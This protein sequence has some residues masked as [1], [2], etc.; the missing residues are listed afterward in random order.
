MAGEDGDAM[1]MSVTKPGDEE[2]VVIT[3]GMTRMEKFV[4]FFGP[5]LLIATVY[6]DPGQIVV[7]MESG[8][9]FQYRLLWVLFAANGMGLLFQHLCSRLSVVTGRNMAVE[10]RL[11]Y[12]KNLRVFLWFTV[13]LASIAADLGYVMGTATALSILFGLQLHWGV[14]LTGLDTFL[15][16]GLQ[17]FGIRKVEALVGSLFGMVVVAYILEMFFIQP[18][19]LGIV[20]GCLPR[21]WHKNALFGYDEWLRL[22]CANLG[23]A[24]CPPN[25]FL[26]S[27]LVRTRKTDR[28]APAVLE[29]FEY[30]LYE[31]TIC[32]V[33][34]TVIN[35]VMLILAAAHFY[36][37]K[38]VS[39]E[40]GADLLADILGSFARYAFAIAMLCAGQSSSLTGVLSTQYIMEGFFELSIPGWI[41]RVATRILA[42]VPAF[43]VVY[44]YGANSA[45]ELIE[46]AQV[47]VNF[48]VP[49]TVI[50]LTKFL[51]SE[52]KMG[53]FRLSNQLQVICWACSGIAI[54]LNVLALYDFFSG[55]EAIPKWMSFVIGSGTVGVYFAMSY[56][57]I[58]RP[59]KVGTA[60]LWADDKEAKEG[61]G[62][63]F[64][65]GDLAPTPNVVRGLFTGGACFVVIIAVLAFRE[66]GS[67]GCLMDHVGVYIGDGC[68]IVA[69]RGRVLNSP[70]P[71]ATGVPPEAS[72]LD[73]SPVAALDVGGAMAMAPAPI[74][75]MVAAEPLLTA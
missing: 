44:T 52:L 37:V 3:M 49:F 29:A 70:P 8:S 1:S 57:L 36:P 22:L 15:A 40:Q 21:L 64:W 34:A 5:G 62:V 14:L 41:V 24:V 17:S 71:D 23:A 67:I 58:V 35:A 63:G 46:Q 42:I 65:V 53:P 48:V 7:D 33:L 50:P 28:T 66:A 39:M 73:L 72:E 18:S 30:N 19:V 74:E 26:Q 32:L 75:D 69:L 56:Y 45:A 54:F 61:Q 55:L 51:S 20:D 6:V 9:T 13:E 38:V 68:D 16:L 12:P 2:E 60:G 59:V 47:V 25:F 10:N 4:R 43:F 11:E 27:A 31:T